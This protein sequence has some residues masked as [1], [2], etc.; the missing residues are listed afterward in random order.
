M[1]RT[2]RQATAASRAHHRTIFSRM[3]PVPV[4][5]IR[6]VMGFPAEPNQNY[7]PPSLVQEP[8]GLPGTQGAGHKKGTGGSD[9][10]SRAHPN[11][12]NRINSSPATARGTPYTNRCASFA[13]WRAPEK[14]RREPSAQARGGRYKERSEQ[15]IRNWRHSGSEWHQTPCG[16]T[17]PVL[18]FPDCL[19]SIRESA[20]SKT[21]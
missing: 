2:A 17:A 14:P 6:D 16:A 9:V 18:L 8:R 7:L 4:C 3:N 11:D 13:A 19:E 5:T 1:T 21:D 12:C 10:L 15:E 20:C